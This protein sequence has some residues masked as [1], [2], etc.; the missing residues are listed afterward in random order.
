VGR[1][2]QF[3]AAKRAPELKRLVAKDRRKAVFSF[4]HP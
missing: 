2:Q 3:N 4:V 1:S